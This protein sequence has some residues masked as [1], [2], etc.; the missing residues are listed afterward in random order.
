M[1]DRASD[2]LEL[3][4]RCFDR[5]AKGDAD[6][7]VELYTDDYLL[8]LPYGSVEESVCIAGR[9]TVREYLVKTFSVLR[10]AV[11]IDTVYPNSDP[12]LVIA[13]YTSE[14]NAVA[15]GRRD[16]NRYVGFWGFRDDLICRTREYLNPLA[17]EATG[18]EPADFR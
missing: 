2:N 18:L 11:T 13:E 6:G 8:E 3:L 1:T 5:I 12:D 7:V 10:F 17:V 15:S 9:A 16:A 14:G 4:R